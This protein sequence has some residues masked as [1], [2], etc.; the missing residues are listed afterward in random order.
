MPAPGTPAA[1]GE[2]GRPGC[3][4]GEVWS[5]RGRGQTPACPRGPLTQAD[6]G[7]LR[8]GARRRI[9][10]RGCPLLHAGAGRPPVDAA[11]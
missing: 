11:S 9:R 1:T 2:E 8:P 7:E 4:Q 6:D 3:D 5:Y 10:P